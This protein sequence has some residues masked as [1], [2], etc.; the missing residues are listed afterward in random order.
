MNKYQSFL[1]AIITIMKK[2]LLLFPP[3]WIINSPHISVPIISASLKN[4]GYSVNSKD[5]NIEFINEVC[6]KSFTEKILKKIN[7]EWNEFLN[8]KEVFSKDSNTYQDKI[9]SARYNELKNFFENQ[10]EDYK[11]IPNKIEN[12]I[13]IIK[14]NF[15]EE[16]SLEYQQIVP[17]IHK[18]LYLVK[19][20]YSTFSEQLPYQMLNF[21]DIK[22]FILDEKHNFF[23]NFYKNKIKDL[24]KGFDCIG[25]SIGT[26]YQL[27]AGLTLAYLLKKQTDVNVFIG[28]NHIS[29]L[30][31]NIQ[32]YPEFFDI[33]ADEILYSKSEDSI[34]KYAQYINEEIDI[35]NVPNVI[36]KKNNSVLINKNHKCSERQSLI[37]PDYSNYDLQKYI[38]NVP[39]L[40]LQIQTSCYWNKCNFCD[41]SYG[42]KYFIRKLEDVIDELKYNKLMYNVSKYF[43]VDEA[44]PP[45]IIEKLS[46]LILKNNL[47]VDFSIYGRLEKGFNKKILEKAYKAG[48]RKIVWG[49]ES[50]N[51]RIAKLIN[52]G[53]DLKTMEKVLKLSHEAKI[54]NAVFVM[55]N[56]PTGTYTETLDTINFLNKNKR[57]INYICVSEFGLG[58]YCKVA[59]D[60]KKY[61]VVINEEQKDFSHALA[62]KTKQLSQHEKQMIYDKINEIRE[63]LVH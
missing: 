5:L 42:S 27:I 33:F 61:G 39:Q 8:N 17:I 22:S 13:K 54:K 37:R 52:K 11:D 38:T 60:P 59:N 7:L 3:F 30:S 31:E 45:K 32:K 34:I 28:G 43:I 25:I 14:E 24:A 44:I 1:Y 29:R 47:D 9:L 16:S 46:D 49:V 26:E 10:Y 12:T 55:L 62:Y 15:Y 51:K 23:L 41:F 4:A 63:E 53:I 48:F 19:L 20:Y 35:E 50:A 56:F 2:F 57:F 6:T 18:A 21:Q 58:R 40:P 36:Y